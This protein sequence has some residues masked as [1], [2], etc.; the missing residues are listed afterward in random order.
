L[1]FHTL[2]LV[3]L[4]ADTEDMANRPR[5]PNQL[6]KLIV[7]IATGEAED[8]VSPKKRA[9]SVKGRSGGLKGGKSRSVALTPEQ[10]QDI[11]RLAAQSRWKKRD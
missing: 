8:A 11:A 4:D 2:A 10:R 6:A 9:T 5:D 7:D 1:D 3:G